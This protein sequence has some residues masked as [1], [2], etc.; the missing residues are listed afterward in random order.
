MPRL[1]EVNVNTL[2]ALPFR[3]LS[4]FLIACVSTV[5]GQASTLH[6]GDQAPPLK[7]DRW[8]KGQPVP[9]FEIGRVYVV[10]FW[11]TWCGPCRQAMPHLSE[12]AKEYADRTTFIGVDI[13][14]EEHAAQGE[15]IKAK[16]NK[17]VAEMGDRMGYNVCAGSDDGYMA[18]NWMK[19]SGQDGI[20]ATFVIGKDGKLAWIGHPMYLDKVFPK[21]VDGSFD[22][23][24]FA[25]EENSRIDKTLEAER[26]SHQVLDPINA[27]VKSALAS[28]DYKLAVRECDKGLATVPQIYRFG[29][30]MQKFQV[31]AQHMPQEAY[32]DAM[33]IKMDA[34]QAWMASEVYATTPGLPRSCYQFALDF[35]H[36]KYDSQPKNVAAPA[37][38]ADVYYQLGEPVKAV[39]YYQK[40]LAGVK[41]LNLDPVTMAGFQKELRKLKDA[42]AAKKTGG[43]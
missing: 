39:E 18:S 22:V 25:A 10:E 38:Y 27:A 2:K 8:I 41:P 30:A 9:S 14:E 1:R 3:L 43:S 4:I 15:N 5:L 12:L 29:L 42:A 40:F 21:I 32:A 19:A 31:I 20:P 13:W 7:V 37:H 34:D 23:N 33:S 11:A 17:F 26:S 24:A 28:K 35:F 36:K 6:I 16:V